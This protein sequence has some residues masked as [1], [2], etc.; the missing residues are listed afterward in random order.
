MIAAAMPTVTVV[1]NTYNRVES[2]RLAL[3]SVLAQ[4]YTDFEVIVVDDGS[5]DSTADYLAQVTDQRVRF[6][7]HPN[8][9]LPASR[10]AGARLASGAWLA[11]LDDDDSVESTWLERLVDLVGQDIGLI[12]CGTNRV[13]DAGELLTSTSPGD[14]GPAFHNL[15]GSF[16]AGSWTV[17]ADVFSE[18]GA[19][20]EGLPFI[21][22]FELL[23]RAATILH[24]RGLR[25]ATTPEALFNYTVRDSASRPMLWP[26]FALDGGRWVL[27]RHADAFSRDRDA[28]ANHEAVVGV[29]AA[30]CGY[31]KVAR[32]HLWRSVRAQPGS[33]KRWLRLGGSAT[34]WSARVVWGVGPPRVDQQLPL[35]R[36]HSLPPDHRRTED[37]LFL[38]WRYVRNSQLSADQIGAPYWEDPSKNNTRYQEPVYRKARQLAER[39]RSASVLDV[40]TGSGVKLERM[41]AP[42]VE[43]AVGLDQGSGIQLARSRAPHLEWVEGDLLSIEPWQ[44]IANRSFDLLICADVIEHVEDP[45]M[46]LRHIAAQMSTSSLLLISTPDRLKLDRPNAFG[47]PDNPRHVREWTHEEFELFLESLGFRV[48]MFY[49]FLPRSYAATVWEAKRIIWRLLHWMQLPDRRSNMAFLCSLR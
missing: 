27:A 49:R 20:L 3:G 36:V 23:L 29:A 40:G 48:E 32:R 15:S 26:R 1:L 2:L 11:F 28:T 42:H 10:N 17:R 22:Q 43:V 41:V 47:P 7:S 46:L 31:N 21:H 37:H 24:E 30:R 44:Q 33:A 16:L 45:V 13:N 34:A 35:P 5:T 25:T 9:G 38:P 14:L 19:Y 39:I 6:V 12:S 18:C 4:T 8:M